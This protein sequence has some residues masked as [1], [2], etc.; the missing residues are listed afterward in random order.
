MKPEAVGYYI[1][2]EMEEIEKTSAGGIVLTPKYVAREQG[3]CDRG[4][5]RGIGPLAFAGYNGI[6]DERPA[7]ERAGQ[8]GIEIGSTVQFDRYDGKE[9]ELE[10]YENYRLISDNKI[11]GKLVEKD[12]E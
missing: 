4:I 9:L 5:V 3:G 7:D 10:G 2:V 12:D 8:W 6:H 1:L 11:M